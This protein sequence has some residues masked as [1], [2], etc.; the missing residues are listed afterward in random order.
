[1]KT[2]KIALALIIGASSG[3]AA[4]HVVNQKGKTFEPTTLEVN[5]GDTIK[6]TNSDAFAHNAYS[7]D[8]AN[9]FDIGMQ[10]PGEDYSI[11]L[12]AAGNLV[13]GCAIH[14]SMQLKVAV[15]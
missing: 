2:L 14:P 9:E 6:F 1:M 3:Y 15:K 11:T 5:V 7:D 13:I 8:G 12:K 4:E 10:A